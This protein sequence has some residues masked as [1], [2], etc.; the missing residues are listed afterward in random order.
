MPKR[1]VVSG[2]FAC[3]LCDAEYELDRVPEPEAVCDECHVKLEK[4]EEEDD[5][6]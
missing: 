1:K 5:A 6:D 4:V 2:M 3:P